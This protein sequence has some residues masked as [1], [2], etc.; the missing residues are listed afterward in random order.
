ME[1]ATDFFTHTMEVMVVDD[2]PVFRR[3]LEVQLEL[4]GCRILPME[5]GEAAWERIQAQPPD[6][7]LTDVFMPGMG[8]L[9]LCRRIKAHPGLQDLPVVLLTMLGAKC[10]DEGF[11]AGADDFLNKPPHLGELRTRLRN[12]LLLRSLRAGCPSVP[13][14]P[15]PEA[16]PARPPRVLVLES[17]GILRDHVRGI[18]AQEG[19]ETQGVDRVDRFMACLETE[20]PDLVIIDQDLMEGPGSA[21]A[22][23]LRNQAATHGLAILLMCEAEAMTSGAFTGSPEADEHLVKPFEASELRA[24]V[25]ALLRHVEL[26]QRQDA[27]HLDADA[28]ALKDP[29]SGAFTRP[30]LY[31]ALDALGEFATQVGR[32]VGLLG[33]QLEEGGPLRAGEARR[34]A[35]LI[36]SQLRTP[37]ILCRMGT[38]LFVAI[39]PGIDATDLAFRREALVPRIPGGKVAAV[40]GRG[41]GPSAWLRRLWEQL[42]QA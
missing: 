16:P 4:L 30:F 11:Q 3:Y 24:R 31:A 33:V 41:E 37:D 18:L 40:C 34:L 27:Q 17:Y 25:K 29:Q 19:W 1:N 9:E 15:R 22:A 21:L 10:K 28:A 32:P 23:R 12:L 42:A 6:L 36:R 2:D 8:G 26:R 7:V 38:G 20:R 14:A 35:G 13:D 5:S 39:L